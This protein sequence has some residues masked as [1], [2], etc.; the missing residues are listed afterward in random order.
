MKSKN[1]ACSI[2]DSKDVEVL[3]NLKFKLLDKVKLPDNYDI[4]CCSRCGFVYADTKAKQEDCDKFYKEHNMY[5]NPASISDIEKYK[6]TLRTLWNRWDN[7]KS[8]LEIGFANGELLRELKSYGFKVNGMDTSRKCV[9]NIRKDGIHAYRR[10][11]LSSNICK[12]PTYDYIVLS[13]VIEHILNL[14]G[15][16]RSVYRLLNFGGEVYIEVPD[17][18]QYRDNNASQF[19]YFD[20]EHL[21][22]FTKESLSN[23]AEIVGGLKVVDSGVKKWSIGNNGSYYPAIWIIAKKPELIVNNKSLEYISGYVKE[24]I[25]KKYYIIDELAKSQEE[26]IV[27]GV[28]SLAQKLYPLSKLGECNISYCVDNDKNKQGNIFGGKK[29]FAPSYIGSNGHQK[30]RILVLSVY[31]SEDIIKQIKEMKLENEVIRIF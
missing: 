21:N 29:V 5:E 20:I 6:I 10:S 2:C 12:T 16:M 30:N 14:K 8:L 4:V 1:R 28:G 15:A 9:E 27:W 24:C 7:N 19:N 23:L 26:I 11:L 22:H 17:L 31:G 3:Y 13:H 25:E 18:W